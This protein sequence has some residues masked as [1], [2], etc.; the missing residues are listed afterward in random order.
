MNTS[1]T[2][3]LK[4]RS[5][6]HI[7]HTHG[8]VAAVD[9]IIEKGKGIMLT[10]VEGREYMDTSSF[11]GCC[12]LGYGR[13]EII[14]AATEQMRKLSFAPANVPY[15]NIPAIEYAEALAKFAPKNITRFQFCSG[16]GEAVE[17]AI[18]TAKAY[19]YL[20]G[21]ASKYKVI[22]LWSSFHGVF[23]LS[24]SLQGSGFAQNN[25]GPEPTGVVRIPHY[26]CYHCPFRLKYPE[27]GI[28]CAHY[29]EDVIIQEGPESIALF[30]AE[31][32]H[33]W[34]G[35]P[36]VPEYWPI[37]RKICTK[38]EILLITDEIVTGFCRTGKNFGIDHFDFQAD[39]MVMGKG[40]SG[41][42]C[43]CGGIGITDEIYSVFPGHILTTGLTNT[44]HP[45]ICSIAK[46]VLD[47]YVREKIS[48]RTAELNKHVLQRFKK[49][50]S[51]LPNVGNAGG[52]GLLLSIEIV[53]DKE[54]RRK[55]PPETRLCERIVARAREK[56]LFVRTFGKF[57]PDLLFFIPPLIITREEADKALDIMY[58]ILAE[59]KDLK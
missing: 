40:M 37:I 46:A 52:L 26:H 1:R 43:P 21:K 45:L 28:R 33:S 10:D 47:I 4:Q 2:E 51:Q 24:G 38:Y 41:V 5:L 31:P 27:C 25:F 56:G 42:Y 3:E 15:D 57:G 44:G 19:W 18:K 9:L 20:K 6:A 17:T 35:G 53:A 29:L 36:P 11:Y 14:N 12:S 8:P 34:A 55:F 23:H 7:F 39:I 59:L 22:C 32:I 48:E 54:T 49:E 58:S 30:I 16:G 50:F 13:E